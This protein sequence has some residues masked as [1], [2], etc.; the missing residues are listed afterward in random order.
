M[1]GFLHFNRFLPFYNLF[2]LLSSSNKEKKA[3][4]PDGE[5]APLPKNKI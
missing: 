4:S 1:I 3:L 2:L 5:K